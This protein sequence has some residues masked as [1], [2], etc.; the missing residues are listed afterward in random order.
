M[1]CP[2]IGQEHTAPQRIDPQVRE[3]AFQHLAMQYTGP[4]AER[5]NRVM[6]NPS[7]ASDEDLCWMGNSLLNGMEKL[8]DREREAATR[9]LL[10]H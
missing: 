8:G 6:S 3:Q 5:I 9:T 1:K 7:G 2:Q 4:A 10:G